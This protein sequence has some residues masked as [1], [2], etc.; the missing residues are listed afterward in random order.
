MKYNITIT[1]EESG[2]IL[3]NE[4]RC[5][6]IIGAISNDAGAQIVSYISA[7]AKVVAI[8]AN[9]I[10]KNIERLK[11]ENDELDILMKILEELDK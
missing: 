10:M 8:I 4:E 7:G 6:A 2:K 11:R 5:N 3:V 9:E 1:E